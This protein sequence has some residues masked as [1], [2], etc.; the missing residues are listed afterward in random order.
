MK[1]YI[2]FLL[3]FLCSI[4]LYSQTY[5]R[6]YDISGINENAVAVSKLIESADKF[7]AILPDAAQNKFK[8]VDA[9]FY[10]LYGYTTAEAYQKEFDALK[11]NAA[12]ESDYY[13][14]IGR[15]SDSTGYYV[16]FFVEVKLP[17]LDADCAN[18][19]FN[20]LARSFLENK[21]NESYAKLNKNPIDASLAISWG[22]E[23]FT[24]YVKGAQEC[25]KNNAKLEQCLSCKSSDNKKAYLNSLGF[26]A[27]SIQNIGK[28]NN[29]YTAPEIQNTAKLLFTIEDLNT[30]DLGAKYKTLID[31]F[32][33]HD[34]SIKIFITKDE[35][36]C[37]PEWEQIL[38]LAK[39]GTYDLVYWH[40]IHHGG[41]GN[42]WLFTTA[43]IKGGSNLKDG[44]GSRFATNVIAGLAGAATDFLLQ[45]VVH[46]IFD[47]DIPFLGN[48]FSMAVGR[49]DKFEVA[50]SG[51]LGLFGVNSNL[52][53]IV[54]ALAGA[55]RQV[56]STAD[57]HSK[58]GEDYTLAW[59]T[60]DFGTFF[61]KN[62]VTE[63]LSA[64]LGKAAGK[65]L[66]KV[67]DIPFPGWCKIA[68]FL[69]KRLGTLI[70][71]CFVEGTLI[72][73]P[74][75]YKPIELLQPDD[76]VLTDTTLSPHQFVKNTAKILENNNQNN[77]LWASNALDA[78]ALTQSKETE[79]QNDVLD[80]PLTPDY[81][82]IEI[83]PD[84]WKIAVL[85]VY[86]T[87]GSI[88]EVKLL[89]PNTW[90]ENENLRQVGDSTWLNLSNINLSGTTVVQAFVA[91]KLDTRSSEARALLACG[92]YPVLATFKHKSDE[93][94]YIRFTNGDKIGT[95][96][97]H[98]FWSLD[99]DGWI[100]AGE[101]RKG[102]R[103]KIATG[104]TILDSSVV[105]PIPTTVYNLESWKVHNYQVGD[106]VVHNSCVDELN[107]LLKKEFKLT[108]APISK[109]GVI[110][111]KGKTAA[112]RIEQEIHLPDKRI[113]PI[114]NLEMPRFE[115]F[116][117]K[118]GT[119]NKPMS[120]PVMK[121]GVS[122]SVDNGA[123]YDELVKELAKVS[124][125]KIT[126]G[127]RNNGKLTI[128]VDGIS[129]EYTWHHHENGEHMMLVENEVHEL[130]SHSGGFSL[131]EQFNLE[132]L[133]FLFKNPKF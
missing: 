124:N 132:F 95:T 14:A 15:Q 49:V 44:D 19:D 30:V 53:I 68:K 117:L 63:G 82:Q 94:L 103:L 84:T 29:V 64:L 111:P 130:I 70:P 18:T 6:K 112:V 69:N 107:A 65:A 119:S 81:D 91:T 104:Y 101:L 1:K 17:K 28:D 123:A 12:K 96:A 80:I 56:I 60:K 126:K 24:E 33:A 75:G 35:D 48:G 122:R 113:V 4:V 8:V 27:M 41:I 85:N 102:E 71:G 67:K 87:D 105:V 100:A 31:T 108:R 11:A 114:S 58:K 59:G 98:P 97:P 79:I 43:F 90:F 131:K 125:A 128:E 32:K 76:W 21:I 10:M 23:A 110:T 118:I 16:R 51:V 54:N 109:V 66:G 55:T 5:V 36:M 72:A 129:K 127:G 38:T 106:I 61:L 78:N 42:E 25:C 40:H 77:E 92:Y 133:Y 62:L 45:T 86:K 93:V 121:Q 13:I 22:L 88:A 73:T 2:I 52:E 74:D 116:T 46:Y 50:K 20:V 57:Y 39:S 99:R 120:F 83:T 7:K 9:G 34:M 115:G 3:S 26:T 47:E 37:T 89:R